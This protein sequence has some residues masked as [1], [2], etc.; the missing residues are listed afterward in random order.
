MAT[1]KFKNP[2]AVNT[3][4]IDTDSGDRVNRYG[5]FKFSPSETKSVDEA[6]INPALESCSAFADAL[7]SGQLALIAETDM[8]SLSMLDVKNF[9]ASGL[10][11]KYYYQ[12]N[13]VSANRILAL[14]STAGTAGFMTA[15]GQEPLGVTATAMTTADY[16]RLHILTGKTVTVHSAGTIATDD[17]VGGDST[18]RGLKVSTSGKYYIGK[19]VTGGGTGAN[20]TVKIGIGK[21]A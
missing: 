17:Y 7:T 14:D 16:K 12:G 2:S 11:E 18:G 1:I 8:D 15:I 6:D 4:I 13:D 3:M 20:I 19:C 10:G 9:L 5:K 21:I